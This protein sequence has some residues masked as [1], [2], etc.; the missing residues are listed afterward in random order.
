[1]NTS[2]Q[3]TIE[4]VKNPVLSLLSPFPGHFQMPMFKMTL[5]LLISVFQHEH[6]RIWREL[7]T[8]EISPPS[9]SPSSLSL[10]CP[11]R[12]RDA[13]DAISQG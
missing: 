5:L 8:S 6:W 2:Q 10:R 11:R 13:E 4:E 3:K 7:I 9:S 1:M 12:S